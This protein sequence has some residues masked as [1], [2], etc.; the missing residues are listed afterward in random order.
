MYNPYARIAFI[1]HDNYGLTY[2]GIEDGLKENFGEYFFSTK[3]EI[4]KSISYMKKLGFIENRPIYNTETG[5][6]IGRGFFLTK[7]G[8]SFKKLSYESVKNEL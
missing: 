5:Y 4:K 8:M 1:L 3:K 7:T 6:F 2:S